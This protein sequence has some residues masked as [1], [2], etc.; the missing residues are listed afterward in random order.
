MRTFVHPFI[1]LLIILTII[2]A[3]FEPALAE[4]GQFTAPVRSVRIIHEFPHDSGAF[5]QGLVYQGGCLY[6]GTGLNGSSSL[7]KVELNTGRVLK[8]KELPRRY[9]GE[10]I[11]ILGGRIYQLT[12]RSGGGF[13][14]DLR[15]FKQ[16]DSFSYDTEGWG[17]TNDGG[18]L[19]MSNGTD[20]LIFMDP[21]SYTVLRKI[22]VRD[23][24]RPVFLLNEL[25]FIKGRI[26]ANILGSDYLAC[27]SPESGQVTEW[28]DLSR[29]RG[30]LK[31]ETADVLNGI[32]YDKKK[33]RLFVTGKNWPVLFEIKID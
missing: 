16:L 8:I 19:I 24:N 32:A 13:V 5:T 31:K 22:R 27:I 30:R 6:E 28:V 15:S 7:R 1:L 3:Q 20:A 17:L 14:Y 11:T 25:E 33:G 2:G 18:H 26:F 9:F 10:G 23:G 4:L 12:W 29:L 21:K